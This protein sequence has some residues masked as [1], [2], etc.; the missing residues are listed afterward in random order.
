MTNATESTLRRRRI[1]IQEHDHGWVTDDGRTF[2]AAAHALETI[3]GEDRAMAAAGTSCITT[4]EW[5]PTTRVGRSVVR[6]LL[7]P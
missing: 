2:P 3:R 1:C 6:V 5:A 7:K 4:I